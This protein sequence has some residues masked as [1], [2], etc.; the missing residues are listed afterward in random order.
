M[1]IMNVINIEIWTYSPS[2]IQI[3]KK[4]EHWEMLFVALFFKA[5]PPTCEHG[6]LL[7]YCG[8]IGSLLNLWLGN[9][10]VAMNASN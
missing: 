7:R 5:Y 1:N 2:G 9:V 6:L 10:H 8:S 4:L 3:L